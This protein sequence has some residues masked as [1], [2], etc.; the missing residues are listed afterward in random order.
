M[1]LDD[2]GALYGEVLSLA[3]IAVPE[4]TLLCRAA[5][6][7]LEMAVAYQSDGFAFLRG[8]DRVN[9]LAAFAY[10]LGWLDAG[11]R[12]GLLEP[13]IAHPPE[14]VDASIP[15]SQDAHLE[16][17]THRYR[18][19]LDAALGAVETAADE[20][21][22]LHAG[23]GEFYSAARAWYAQGVAYLDAGDRAAALARFSY[24]YAWLDAGIRVGL[25]R[26]TGERHLF[27][28]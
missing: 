13:S 11:L 20:A 4:D 9:A 17:K 15:E 26:I 3:G 16:E 1:N 27:T 14:T 23:A 12:L 18:W 22:P 2:Y 24:G 7:V 21:S 10:G 25:F 28:V 5:G 8:G 6:E 19:M